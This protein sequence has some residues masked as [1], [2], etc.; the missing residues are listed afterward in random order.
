MR[1]RDVIAGLACSTVPGLHAARAQQAG[2]P[3]IGFLYGGIREA[4]L[5][6]AE[7]FTKGVEETGFFGGR[8]VTIEY[9]WTEGRS[10]RVPTLMAE[11]MARRVAVVVA[12]PTT[13][14]LA[15]QS[16][17]STVPIVF[18]A[19]DDPVKLGLVASLNRPGGNMTGVNF[20]LNE[21]GT[22]RL[23]LLRDLLPTASRIGLLLN[24][25]S[26]PG[27]SSLDDIQAAGRRLGYQFLVRP[28]TN[29][30]DV[31]SAFAALIEARADAAMVI[32]D[33]LAFSFRAQLAAQ[34]LRAA[35][36]TIYPLRGFVEAGGL[37]SYGSSI[38]ETFKLMGNYAGRILKGEKPADLPVVQ[39][40]KFEL[41]VN[42]K[43]AKA[44]DCK[45]PEDLLLRADEVIE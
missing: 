12:A 20:M 10:E 2:T 41:I 24:P 7:A 17:S 28:I 13:V 31:Q 3:V 9:R 34:A 36:P 1:R 18:I 16:A 8:N 27:V 37:I 14:A 22:K 26:R 30:G 6:L 23:E 29:E 19:T 21:L 42:L 15:V 44:I 38:A 11:L 43:A 40:T 5:P 33:G 39:S 45:I 25:A 32:P 4:D 35:I